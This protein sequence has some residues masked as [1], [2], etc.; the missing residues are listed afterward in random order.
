MRRIWLVPIAL[1]ACSNIERA[2]P[3]TRPGSAT[4]S[5]VTQLDVDPILRGTVASEAV[6]QGFQDVVVRGYGLVVGLQGT[7]SRTMPAEVRAMLLKELARYEVGDSTRGMGVPPARVLDS[8][9]VAAVV[10]EGV[11][12]AG[13]TEGTQFDIRV[14]AVPGSSTTSLEGGRLW[15]CELRPGPAMAGSRQARILATGR[16]PVV[17]NPF[18]PVGV[19]GSVSIDRTTGRVLNGGKVLKDM[20]LRL[21]LAT[22]SH[23]RAATI[24]TALNSRFPRETGQSDET[25]RGKSGE[26]IDIVVP[27]S[28]HDRTSDFV[29]LVRHATLDLQNGEAVAAAVR[30]SLLA[31]PGAAGAANW[32]WQAIGKRSVPMIQDLYAYPEE[33]PRMAALEAGARLDDPLVVPHLLDMARSGSRDIRLAA[34][35]LLGRMDVNPAIDVGLRPLLDDADLD[36]RLTTYESLRRRRDPIVR[37]LRCGDRLE[38]DVVPSAWPLVYITQTGEPRVAVF[39]GDLPLKR[40]LSRSIAGGRIIIKGEPEDEGVLLF[41]RPSPEERAR[42][43][44]APAEVP[45]LIQ[46]LARPS[47]P[48]VGLPGLD[49]RYGEIIAVLYELSRTGDL[50][51]ELR[52]E[53]D[54][55]LAEIMRQD[56]ASEP[57]ERPEFPEEAS[58]ATVPSL[59]PTTPPAA[60]PLDGSRRTSD[61]VPR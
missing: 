27:P 39:G 33:Q 12:P 43:E 21:R 6:L 53:Q 17:I 49:L 29:Q 9:D 46:F 14:A 15:T 34:I 8:E 45:A 11:I 18:L 56:D 58:P 50:G 5:G 47:A 31:T 23:T 20:P 30:R 26:T 28:F 35:R 19:S 2:D 37:R 48:N 22:P 38:L 25:A 54:R 60:A 32:R 10:V 36:V 42:V 40:P 3:S 7:G 55:I 59:A 41:F 13:A 4:V 57:D 44:K 24:V 61:T 16:G 51:A 1:A 52:A